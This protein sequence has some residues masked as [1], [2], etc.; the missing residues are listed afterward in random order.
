MTIVICTHNRANLLQHT[1]VSIREAYRPPHCDLNVLVIANACKDRTIE[2]L[3]TWQNVADFPSL[4]YYEEPRPGKS[5][6]LNLAIR[7]IDHGWLAFVDDDHRIDHDYL[8][9]IVDAI[10][11]WPEATMFCGRILPDWRGDEP[12]WVH[13]TGPYR[14]YPLP[15]PCFELGETP[16]SV[17][18]DDRIPGGGNL[19]VHRDVFRRVGEFSTH[20]GPEGHNLRGGEDSDLVLRAL[21]QGETLQYVPSIVQYHHIDTQRLKL[22]YLL[23]KS[24]QRSFSITLARHPHSRSIPPYLLR[25]L[26]HHLV[27]LTV[28]FDFMK[29][30]FH[31]M[32]IAGTLGEMTGMITALNRAPEA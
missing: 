20:L 1:L 17:T 6:A 24:F 31:L 4:R 19:I 10:H 15:I 8:T 2:L 12:T 3:K 22:P 21:H 13:D 23:K 26:L 5:L 29:F 25:K 18:K 30:R 7:K 11:A 14:V 16:F 9:A 27:Q 28:S 32:R